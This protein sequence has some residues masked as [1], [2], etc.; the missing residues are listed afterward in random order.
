MT[1]KLKRND[2]VRQLCKDQGQ[3][4]PGRGKNKCENADLGMNLV[5]LEGH[6]VDT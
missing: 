5:R 4:V 6:K 3:G 2:K 1:L